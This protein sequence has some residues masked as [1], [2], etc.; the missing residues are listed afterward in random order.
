MASVDP[1]VLTKDVWTKVLTNV[2]YKGQVHILE[3]EEDAPTG[4]FVAF[5]NTG[6]AA[7]AVSFAGGV[8]IDENFSPAN[9]T[10]SDYY[11]MPKNEA[12]LVEILV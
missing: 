8:R 4:Y 7:P 1:T 12:G 6:D 9:D 10:A 2:T 3:Q 5:V 11:L